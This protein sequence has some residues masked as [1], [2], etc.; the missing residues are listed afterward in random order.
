LH[1]AAVTGRA[2]IAELLI[3]HGASPARA[4]ANG[5]S[6]LD[7]ATRYG[8]ADV[9]GVLV[10]HGAPGR[11]AEGPSP[12]SLAAQP[13]LAD[14]EAI[15]WY[16]VHS[17]YAIKTSRH[18]L[19]FDYWEQGNP[20]G[21]PGLANGHIDP[22]E[23]AGE[24]VVVFASHAHRDHYD[25]VVFNWRD[26]VPDIRYVIGFEPEETPPYTYIPPRETRE[27]GDL[28]ITTI[29]SNDSGVGFMV[30]VDGL[31]V[32]HAG[33]HANRWQDFSG[34]YTAEIDWL[35]DAGFRPDIALLP[36]TGCRFHDQ[37]AVK[38]GIRYALA[39]LEPRVFIPL[40]GG[41]ASWR[42]VEV[43]EA[44][45]DSAPD[46]RMVAPVD[47]GDRFHYADRTIERRMSRR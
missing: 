25:P 8:N 40:H 15:L 31:V 5:A 43:I 37:V 26:A 35:R 45:R 20:P 23:I 11:V 9:A 29:E 24:R 32:F 38:M 13:A 3:A 47:R 7:L 1:R 42:Y 21:M 30:E 10:A 41:D 6:P 33:D 27:L 14:G 28:R 22:A 12:G 16:L 34:P 36:S 4:D 17:G 39:A 46:V 19:V 44:C 18:L 2:E